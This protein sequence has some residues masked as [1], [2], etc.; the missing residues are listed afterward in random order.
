MRN[1][2]RVV[3]SA[4]VSLGLVAAASAGPSLGLET[5]LVLERAEP[6]AFPLVAGDIAAPIHLD[7]ADHAGVIRAAGDLREDIARVT[8]RRPELL[9]A[10]APRGPVAVIAGTLGRSALVDGLV[11]DGK[12]DVGTIA[13]R[14]ESFVIATVDDPLPGLKQALV[15]AGS[16]KRGTIYG[17]YEISEQI[18]VSPWHWG[19]TSKPAPTYRGPP[20]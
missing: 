9:T 20:W 8:G 15:I 5:G 18:G 3:L 1:P 7:T 14:W 4:L 16:D 17:L 2:L 11:R 19:C 13:G 12:L 10:S 6:G